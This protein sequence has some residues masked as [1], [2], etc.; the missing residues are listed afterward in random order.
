M[1][2]GDWLW[3]VSGLLLA[4]SAV[5]LFVATLL[6][7]SAEVQALAWASG[8][9]Q[10]KSKSP[11]VNF[12]RQMVH[13]FTLQH[14]VRIRSKSYRQKISDKLLTSGLSEEL[15]V[16]EFIGLQILWGIG[17]PVGLALLNFTLQ[18]GFPWLLPIGLGLVGIQAPHFWC[19]AQ[20][21][22][23]YTAVVIDLPFFIDLLALST[24]A[25]MEFMNAI[26]RIVEKSDDSVLGRE[27]QIVLRDT[28]LGSSRTDALRNMAKRLDIPEITSFVSVIVDAMSTGASVAQVLKEQS[29]QMRLER[30]VRAEKAGARASQMLLL[31]MIIFILPAVLIMVLAPF[32]I[33]MFRGGP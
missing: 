12:S 27:F 32:L 7:R 4:G 24:E 17:F 15:T 18:L 29:A 16:D 3:L 19:S 6:G 26:Q 10:N 23:R 1:F 8:E 11:F 30:F 31:P 14:A 33:Q 21:A 5:Y 9:D 22:Q 25:G 2:G 13:N 28:K 20:K